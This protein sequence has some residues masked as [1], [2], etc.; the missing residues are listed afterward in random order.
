MKHTAKESE[1]LA[2]AMCFYDIYFALLITYCSSDV[3]LVHIQN[4]E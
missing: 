4:T 1:K 3:F 2:D